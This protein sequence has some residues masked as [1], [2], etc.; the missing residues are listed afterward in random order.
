MRALCAFGVRQHR[1]RL[2]ATAERQADGHHVGGLLQALA[3]TLDVGRAVPPWGERNPAHLLITRTQR[4]DERGLAGP[5]TR[6][7]SWLAIGR[8]VKE[9]RRA[10]QNAHQNRGFASEITRNVRAQLGNAAP[11]RLGIQEDFQLSQAPYSHSM[12]AGGLELT[13]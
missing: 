11:N 10:G 13:S 8:T 7:V 1:D 6:D 9:E 12:V 3:L 5:V 2:P 4:N